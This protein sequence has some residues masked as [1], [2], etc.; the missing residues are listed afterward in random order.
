METNL[1]FASVLT[2]QFSYRN[3]NLF[4]IESCI[5]QGE[6][7]MFKLIIASLLLPLGLHAA[8]PSFGTN[9][10]TEADFENISKELSGNF[11]HHSV[12]GAATLGKIFGFE[13]G[14]LAGQQAVPKINSI[15]KAN[16]GSDFPTLYH[17]GLLGVLSVPLGFTGEFI[18]IPK[19][20]ASDASVEMN[21]LAIKWTANESLVFLPVN[22]A[23]RYFMST[24][25]FSFKQTISASDATVENVGSVSGLQL[26]VS[27]GLPLVEPYAGFGILSGKNKL[28]VTGTTG[29]VFDT[30]YTTS[31]SAEKT[32]SST[33]IL[34]GVNVNLLVKLG[35]EYSNAFGASAYTAKLGFGF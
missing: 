33:Q 31:Q 3:L 14:L 25:K 22:V 26:L 18:L 20:T 15:V 2:G 21:S 27:P 19:T 6:F 13:V 34:L 8:G 24:S 32:V 7:L 1:A 9:T 23:L 35:L 4:K 17:A 28:D 30:T 10:L 12:Q 5:K 11:M 16:G 29:S